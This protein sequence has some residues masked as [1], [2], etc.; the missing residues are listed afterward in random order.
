MTNKRLRQDWV[1]PGQSRVLPSRNRVVLLAFGAS[2]PGRWGQPSDSIAHA[3][4]RLSKLG[5]VLLRRSANYSTPPLG[6]VR[7]GRYVNAVASFKA[8]I[9]PGQLL[10]ALKQLEREAGRR[11]GLRWGP[12][13]LDVD[14]L[15][16]GGRTI[17]YRGRR[18]PQRLAGRLQLPH[19]EMANRGF[20]LVPLAEVAPG[21]RH[22]IDGWTAM[23]RLNRVPALARGIYRIP[24]QPPR[25]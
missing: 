23:E 13:P 5:L 12:R 16:M 2:I 15:D 7:Q 3:I 17:G 4:E 9:A 21:W 11:P 10:R 1:P 24:M 18:K 25:S 8:D 6:F 22:P 20:V 14:I 19:P